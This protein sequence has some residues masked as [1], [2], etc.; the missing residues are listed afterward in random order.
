VQRYSKRCRQEFKAQ[1]D[2]L[3]LIFPWTSHSTHL[4]LE[5]FKNLTFSSNSYA[6]YCAAVYDKESTLPVSLIS[7][8]CN[9]LIVYERSTFLHKILSTFFVSGICFSSCRLQSGV[10]A[11][12]INCT[13]G[14]S[15]L[16]TPYLA[17]GGESLSYTRSRSTQWLV[18]PPP[19]W[20]QRRRTNAPFPLKGWGWGTQFG[21]LERKPGTLYTLWLVVSGIYQ[22][23]HNGAQLTD[24]GRGAGWPQRVHIG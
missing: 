13:A 17:Y 9:S 20:T 19:P 8:N 22:R 1:R 4:I 21:G 18:D 11:P 2:F 10:Y 23:F 6:R 24:V 15:L 12:H 3:P 14:R 7:G 5:R 16:I